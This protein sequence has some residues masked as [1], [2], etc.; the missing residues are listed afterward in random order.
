M[1]AFLKDS[2]VHPG[3]TMA[4][5]V[6]I[7]SGLFSAGNALNTFAQQIRKWKRLS[8]RLFDIRE[9]LDFSQLALDRWQ[10]KYDIQVQRPD[11]H[12]R[13]L[14]GK[15]G[16][17]RIMATLG[18]INII[19][20]AIEKDVK[21]ARGVA[22]KSQ[23][24][25]PGRAGIHDTM[26]DERVN[27]CLRRIQRSNKWSYKFFL[28]VMGKAD[29]LEV[30]LKR[31]QYKITL[32]DQF[33]DF[34]FEREHPETFS[35]IKRLPGRRFVIKSGDNRMDTRPR[36]I[37]DVVSAQKDAELLHRCSTSSQGNRLHIGLSV[38]R[39]HKRDFAFL[40]TMGERSHEVLVHPKKIKNARGPY[41]V[42]T[43]L[44]TAAS[45]L[46]RE[47]M[48]I[49]Y[50]IPS[51]SASAGFEVRHPPT[52]LLS[53][54]EY[55]DALA[56]LIRNQNAYLSSRTLY[57]QDQ[58]AIASGIA[59]GCVR[60]IGS[61]WLTFLDC[62]NV[63]WRR[64]KDGQWTCMLTATPGPPSTTRTLEQCHE[65]NH[66]R[67]D[68]RD[69]S[70]HIQIFRIGL[71][72]AEL[73]LKA[74]ISYIEYDSTTYTIRMYINDGQE[75]GAHEIASEVAL[76]SNMLLANMVFFCLNALQDSRV[77]AERSIEG[78]YFED[79]FKQA[80]ELDKKGPE[81]KQKSNGKRIDYAKVS[82]GWLC[83]EGKVVK[84]F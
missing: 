1:L 48:S 75:V 64:T 39:I 38:P 50:L 37:L 34:Y 21:R 28:S 58:N 9:G 17:D 71:V 41:R 79:V 78:S 61:Q 40:I 4:E 5:V 47:R 30:E 45:E 54:L 67:W 81:S 62:A 2:I 72:L 12:T 46:V 6:A 68:E 77:M 16:H 36:D 23:P 83:K 56:N 14:F 13:G 60:L 70:Q 44:T 7:I 74:P 20:R 55:K 65:A 76:K 52:S 73:A 31:L 32:L 82:W 29:E 18:M 35:K 51:S 24:T 57:S 19:T 25:A 15:E 10:D 43:D 69:L 26:N 53:D 33:S 22:L 84:T 80:E 27:E 3:E 63:R 59:Q 42:P 11:L 49:T 66:R 8:E